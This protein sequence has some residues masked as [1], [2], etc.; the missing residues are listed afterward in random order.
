MS[1]V[2]PNTEPC[3]PDFD[4]ANTAAGPFVVHSPYFN[5]SYLWSDQAFNNLFGGY[6][7]KNYLSLDTWHNLMG[8]TDSNNGIN[9]MYLDGVPVDFGTLLSTTTILALFD[10]PGY[11]IIGGSFQ[12]VFGGLSVDFPFIPHTV[13]GTKNSLDVADFYSAPGQFLDL[14]IEANRHKFISASG[15]PVDLGSDCSNPTGTGPAICF[16]GDSTGFA[17]NKGTGGAFTL[18][19]AL[20]DAST[21]PSN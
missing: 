5:I 10:N 4:D 12:S 15:K 6:T 19:G 11:E 3:F 16:S 8:A 14:S 13:D 21:S 20:M 17:T 7:A 1:S 9:L 18:I 2:N